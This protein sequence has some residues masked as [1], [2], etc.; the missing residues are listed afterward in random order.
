MSRRFAL[1]IGNSE[2][3]D[4]SLSRLMTPDADV[5]ALAEVLQSPDIGG[6]DEVTALVNQ[7]ATAVRRAI[8]RFFAEK[9]RDDLLV[10]YFSGH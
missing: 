4:A 5:D 6:F 10:L 3:E 9:T 7:P 2:Y 1:I 8:A